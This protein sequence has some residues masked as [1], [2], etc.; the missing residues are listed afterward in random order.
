MCVCVSLSVFVCVCAFVYIW[1]VAFQNSKQYIL[2]L[3]KCTAM[4]EQEKES[5]TEERGNISYWTHCFESLTL[6]ISEMSEA[7]RSLLST[8]PMKGRT[9]AMVIWHEIGVRFSY[10]VWGITTKECDERLAFCVWDPPPSMQ[11][12]THK[13][14]YLRLSQQKPYGHLILIEKGS[15]AQ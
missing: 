13:D 2:I 1:L 7:N 4:K 3:Q 12:A 6:E 15:L 14:Q 9:H 8:S 5:V 10:S 11:P